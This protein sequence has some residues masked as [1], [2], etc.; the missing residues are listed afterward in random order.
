MRLAQYLTKD[1]DLALAVWND[2]AG[3]WVSVEFPLDEFKENDSPI[4]LTVVI[5]DLI[6]AEGEGDFWDAAHQA[7]RDVGAKPLTEDEI[8]FLPPVFSPSKILCVGLNYADHAKE[9]NDPIPSEPVFF[10]KANSTLNAHGKPIFL[11]PVSD[12]IDYEAELVVV[13]GREGRDIPEKDALD[14]VFGY[15]CGNDVSCR[16]WQ[17]NKPAGQWFLG[18]S[19]DSFAPC[20][21]GIVTKDEIPN[22]NALAIQSR[23]NGAVMQS[24]NTSHFIFPVEKLI[25]YVSQVMTLYPGDLIFTGTPGGIGERREPP[26]FLRDG[27]VIEVEIE[28]IGVL[29][30]PVADFKNE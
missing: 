17:K 14:Y 13:I 24:S 5:E 23:L 1:S 28:K 6:E 25:A 26:V 29:S 8:D 30:N 19:F 27:D 20:G 9:F 4:A 16:D 21:P 12:K 15:T 2:A 18:K 10:C 3:G 11:P 22:P 7:A